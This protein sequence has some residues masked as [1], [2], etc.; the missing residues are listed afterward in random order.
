MTVAQPRG[1]SAK[2]PGQ[3]MPTAMEA[4]KPLVAVPMGRVLKHVNTRDGRGIQGLSGV[5]NGWPDNPPINE[6]YPLNYNLGT[7]ERF[8]SDPQT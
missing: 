7:I 5:I 3:S 8:S 1:S 6:G 4:F 2:A